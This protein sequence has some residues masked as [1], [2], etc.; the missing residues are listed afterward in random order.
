MWTN[1]KFEEKQPTAKFPVFCKKRC[2]KFTGHLPI[3]SSNI[4]LKFF[5]NIP[6]TF[7]VWIKKGHNLIILWQNYLK[8]AGP[9]ALLSSNT[10]LNV[11]KFVFNS[12]NTFRVMAPDEHNSW[13]YVKVDRKQRCIF[14]LFFVENNWN[15]QG[16]IHSCHV[17][18][19]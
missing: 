17:T 14:H 4:C 11:Y 2:L 8:L 12:P 9:H 5:F 19:I 18:Y 15:L 7:R 1:W 16:P 6:N 10:C 13:K 3:M